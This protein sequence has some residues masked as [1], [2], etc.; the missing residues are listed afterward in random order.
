MEQNQE[1]VTETVETTQEETTEVKLFTQE[2]VNEIVKTLKE[3]NL[4]DNT[5]IVF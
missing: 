3:Q 2:E 4:L 1:T 5:I